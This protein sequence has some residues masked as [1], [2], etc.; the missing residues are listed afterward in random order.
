MAFT[1]KRHMDSLILLSHGS[2]QA[3]ANA[4]RNE[5]R[6]C[7]TGSGGCAAGAAM[8]AL[9]HKALLLLSAILAASLLSALLMPSTTAL[10]LRDPGIMICVYKWLVLFAFLQACW[11]RTSAAPF[12]NLLLLLLRSKTVQL[13][14]YFLHRP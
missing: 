1:A 3:C 7:C 14:G 5:G 11:C 9:K 12:W 2:C 10:A 4:R 6:A 13:R 8:S